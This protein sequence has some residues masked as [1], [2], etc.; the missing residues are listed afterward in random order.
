LADSVAEA[1]VDEGAYSIGFS[2]AEPTS[3]TGY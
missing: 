2:G 1:N 3:L